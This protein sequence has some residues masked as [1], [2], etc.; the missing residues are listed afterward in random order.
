MSK[1]QWE[2]IKAKDNKN[3][4]EKLGK[5]GVTSFKPRSFSDWQKSG[6]K[7]LF[8]VDPNSVKYAEEIPYMQRGGAPDD[9]DLQKKSPFD[10]FKNFG[11]KTAPPTPPPPKKNPWTF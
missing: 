5:T 8:A 2:A 7:N 10:A 1:S 4:G 9:S 6:G 3:K 11:N